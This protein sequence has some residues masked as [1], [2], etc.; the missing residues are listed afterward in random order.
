VRPGLV[1]SISRVRRRI[2]LCLA[3]VLLALWGCGSDDDAATPAACL[4]GPEPYLEAL[5][6]A[7]GEVLLEDTTP[8][9]G[10]LVEEQEAGAIGTVGEGMIAAATTLNRQA[11]R[12]PHGEATVQLGYLVGATRV[13]AA[14]TGGIHE[15]LVRRVEAAALFIPKDQILPAG[16][17]KGYDEGFAAASG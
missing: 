6:G 17:Q 11:R 8:I 16:F 12:E 7:P 2:A 10:C 9:G 13:A 3:G 4:A 15:D 1:T 5:A 14:R